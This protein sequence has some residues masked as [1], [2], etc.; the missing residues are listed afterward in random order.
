MLTKYINR[1]IVTVVISVSISTVTAQEFKAPTKLPPPESKGY[2]PVN[3]IKM[4]YETYGTGKPIVLVHGSYMTIPLN[5]SEVIPIL[6]KTNRVI[7]VELQGHGRTADTGRP[8]SYDVLADDIAGLL[9]HL[10]LDSAILLGYSFGAT[11]V[12]NTAIR[13]PSKVTKLVFISSTFKHDGWTPDV[14][15]ILKMIVPEC[16]EKTP[17]KT[18]Y[19]SLAPYPANWKPFVKK[20]AAFDTT[21]FDLGKSNLRK[22]KCPVL[23]IKADND[24]VDLHHTTEMYSLL[25][26]NISADMVPQPKSQLVVI[27]NKAHVTLMMD[28]EELMRYVKPFVWQ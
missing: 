17:L 24:G 28:T 22:I 13:H 23:I 15:Q 10:R 12:L 16:F 27:P 8:F 6:S 11:I 21:H 2:A 14:R 7:A 5:F 1:I 20:L 18:Y 4:Y 9:D 19:D 3:G 25:G 26:G